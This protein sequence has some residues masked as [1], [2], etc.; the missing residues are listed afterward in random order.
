ML[1]SRM[2]C[3]AA[4][5]SCRHELQLLPLLR[6]DA[7]ESVNRSFL[8]MRPKCLVEAAEPP[9]MVLGMECTYSRFPW[10]PENGHFADV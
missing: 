2:W 1:S 6:G 4:A 10:F 9:A 7:L 3:D 8:G 5:I